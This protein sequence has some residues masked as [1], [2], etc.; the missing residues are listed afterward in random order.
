MSLAATAGT[1]LG[2]AGSARIADPAALVASVSV[3][4][5]GSV[6]I[7]RVF[8]A[9]PVASRRFRHAP[10][11]HRAPVPGNLVV[12]RGGLLVSLV[13]GLC[14]DRRNSS[15]ASTRRESC[16]VEGSPSFVKMLDTY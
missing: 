3:A 5:R 10:K 7:T 6:W 2:V 13:S 15:T 14:Q 16:L 12:S 1:S 9:A 8:M 4:G 11:N